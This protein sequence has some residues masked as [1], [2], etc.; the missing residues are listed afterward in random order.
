MR[1]TDAQPS[2]S[3]QEAL[4]VK[5]QPAATKA[6]KPD[7]VTDC[8]GPKKCTRGGYPVDVAAGLVFTEAIDFERP[9]SNAF[10]WERIWY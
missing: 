5:Y 2:A 6:K 4:G 3:Q 9:G 10:V 7:A 8:D 1:W